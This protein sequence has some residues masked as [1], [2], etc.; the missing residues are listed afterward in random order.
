MSPI[1]VLVLNG[2]SLDQLG[3][4]EPELYGTA[5]LDEILARLAAVA[6]ALGVEL[7]HT[8]SSHEGALIDA[9]HEARRAGVAG[10]V[11]N[12]AAYTHTSVALRDA[13]LSAALP[14]VEVHLSN[15]WRRE[16]FRHVSLLSDV[17]VGIVAGF[18]PASYELA[19]RGLIEHLLGGA[20]GSPEV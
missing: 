12:A 18:G 3:R 17:A 10:A 9:I 16:A 6:A 14:F 19:L 7:S 1:R 5:T 11:V 20:S 15:V 2:P 8:Q 4:R 13:L